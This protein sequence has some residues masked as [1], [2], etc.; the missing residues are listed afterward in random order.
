MWPKSCLRC[1]RSCSLFFASAL[2]LPTHIRTLSST[3]SRDKS[4]N[5]CLSPSGK[6]QISH[7][8]MGEISN[9]FTLGHIFLAIGGDFSSSVE[10]SATLLD[11]DDASGRIA[12]FFSLLSRRV[13]ALAIASL[14]A[15]R[16]SL[17]AKSVATHSRK[18]NGEPIHGFAKTHMTGENWR[19]QHFDIYAC[20]ANEEEL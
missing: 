19:G 17:T 18:V 5:S 4:S 2:P 9:R 13:R 8:G 3:H 10:L 15:W 11:A 12:R 14:R 1:G 6:K 20:M 7:E 16:G